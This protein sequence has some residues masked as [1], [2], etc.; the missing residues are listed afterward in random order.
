MLTKKFGILLAS[1]ETIQKSVGFLRDYFG[2]VFVFQRMQ[3]HLSR[4]LNNF[5]GVISYIIITVQREV[6]MIWMGVSF[7]KI[8][9]RLKS[10]II[11]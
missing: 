11:N 2:Q 4:Y 8:E 1:C 3:R 10:G 5:W 9:V 7:S 6:S